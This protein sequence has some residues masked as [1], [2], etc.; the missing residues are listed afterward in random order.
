[1]AHRAT[2]KEA[3]ELKEELEAKYPDRKFGREG[4]ENVFDKQVWNIA[5]SPPPAH[6]AIDENAVPDE[7][8][9]VSGYKQLGYDVFEI[10]TCSHGVESHTSAIGEDYPCSCISKPWEITEETDHWH[11]QWYDMDGGV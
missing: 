11:D 4:G 8:G 7:K 9:Y 3:N 6:I 5:F 2:L 10:R 1:M